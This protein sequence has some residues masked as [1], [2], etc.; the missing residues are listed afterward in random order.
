M[1]VPEHAR[2]AKMETVHQFCLCSTTA[3]REHRFRLLKSE[4]GSRYLWHG[5]PFFNWHAILRES[6]KNC[7]NTPLM[8]SGASYG[9]G[10]YL[11]SDSSTSSGYIGTSPLAYLNS[12]WKA[13]VNCMALCEVANS[14]LRSHSRL[15]TVA[16][17]E[18]VI[19]RYI[20]I[21]EPGVA[22]NLSANEVGAAF[23]PFINQLESEQKFLYQTST[24][25]KDRWENQEEI[26]R[27]A[28]SKSRTD[29]AASVSSDEGGDDFC[30][31]SG[32]DGAI[33]ESPEQ[34]TRLQL[35]G[36]FKR[37]DGSSVHLRL[38]KELRA[39]SKI[40]TRSEGFEV[41]SISWRTTPKKLFAYRRNSFQSRSSSRR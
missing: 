37:V 20:F 21:L 30:Y 13:G 2:F 19:I 18:A 6:L 9:P 36:R 22:K 4:S 34:P 10:I 7:S 32:D 26:E 28:A 17:A 11:A 3:E 33:I 16:N 31:S 14:A 41:I 39:L 24:E 35:E 38:M 15:H 8:S 29:M 5:S 23:E 12:T 1:P 27:L 25:L 40:D